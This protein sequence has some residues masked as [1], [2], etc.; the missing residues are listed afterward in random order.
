[1]Q[2]LTALS[3]ELV[4]SSPK[5][6]KKAPN[7]PVSPVMNPTVSPKYICGSLFHIWLYLEI[8]PLQIIRWGQ[9]DED[10][11][12]TLWLEENFGTRDRVGEHLW[13]QR[14]GVIHLPG[15]Q[16][17]QPPDAGTRGAEPPLCFWVSEGFWLCH[18]L[19]FELLASTNYESR[20]LGCFQLPSF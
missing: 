7:L 16:C 10:V 14:L 12:R 13:T 8:G 4:L 1:M 11:P 20:S 3:W 2:K 18:H 19:D 6:L 15:K 17:Q 5:P 9:E